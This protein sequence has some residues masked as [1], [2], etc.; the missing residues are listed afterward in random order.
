MAI[1]RLW[2]IRIHAGD[3]EPRFTWCPLLACWKFAPVIIVVIAVVLVVAV[4]PIV[5]VVPVVPVVATVPVVVV[6]VVHGVGC[7]DGRGS[8]FYGRGIEGVVHIL[9]VCV[10]VIAV[11]LH[12]AV[13]IHAADTVPRFARYPSSAS[14]R[15]ALVRVIVAVGRLRAVR[16]LA[17]DT[18][19]RHAW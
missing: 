8:L 15:F 19:P 17:G 10:E 4:V 9:V 13:W 6:N 5:A 16:I 1:V 2:A 11:F 3:P 7:V 12:R 18:V 14:W